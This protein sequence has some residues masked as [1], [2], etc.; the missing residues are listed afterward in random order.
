MLSIIPLLGGLIACD[1]GI[2]CGVAGSGFAVGVGGNI[3]QPVGVGVSVFFLGLPKV[4]TGLSIE[5]KFGNHKFIAI[6][7]KLVK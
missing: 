5:L 7:F 2:G 6:L 1:C 3:P 4:P